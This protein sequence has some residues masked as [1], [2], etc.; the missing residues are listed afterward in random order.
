MKNNALKLFLFVV[1]LF[2][3]SSLSAA[4]DVVDMFING[5]VF[6]YIISF[7]L[8]V[9]IIL[10]IIKYWQLSIK[11]KINTQKFYLKLKGYIKNN[12]IEE[13]IRICAQFKKTT[14]G[15]IFWNGLLGYND[16]R[17]SGKKGIELKQHLQNSFDEAGLQSIPHVEGGLFWFDIIAQISTLLGLLGTIFGLVQA[18]D[19]LANAP[20]A[21]KSR[22]LTEG[23]S[24][25]MGTTAYGLIVAIPTMLIKGGLQS[26]ADKIINDIDEYS[27]K[28]INQITYSMKD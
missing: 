13:A 23:I 7:L 3:V 12:Q 1:I 11:E 19:S 10:G 2:S 6:M 27:V 24:M 9:M 20:E 8:V 21:D 16:G 26:R 14:I 22:L 17:K 4:V 5:G 28:A 15:F 25:A 18:F